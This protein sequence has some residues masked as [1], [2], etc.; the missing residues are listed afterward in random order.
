MGNAGRRTAGETAILGGS[1][2][3]NSHLACCRCSIGWRWVSQFVVNT[4]ELWA[5]V[6]LAEVVPESG[7]T[8]SVHAATRKTPKSG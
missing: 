6:D 1:F 5:Y 8:W 7:E 4:G 3:G 2:L